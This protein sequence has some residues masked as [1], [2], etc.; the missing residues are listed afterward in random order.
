MTRLFVILSLLATLGLLA[1]PGPVRADQPEYGVVGQVQ[2]GTPGGPVPEGLEVRL[3]VFQNNQVVDTLTTKADAGGNFAFTGL[4]A[5][6]G[7][8]YVPWVWYQG[9]SYFGRQVSFV[10]VDP[11]QRADITIYEATD[12][13]EKVAIQ[14]LSVAVADVNPDANQVVIFSLVTFSNR[15]DRTYVSR[16]MGMDVGFLPLPIPAGAQNIVF[17]GGPQPE[18]LLRTPQGYGVAMSVPPGDL[19]L[20]FAYVIPYDGGRLPVAVTPAFPVER[21]LVLVPRGALGAEGAGLTPH[22]QVDIQNQTFDLYVATGLP[23]NTPAEFNLTGLPEPGLL[24]RLTSSRVLPFAVVGGGGV[25]LA[26]LGLLWARRRAGRRAVGGPRD[27]DLAERRTRLVA[28]LAE[29][30]DRYERGE[31]KSDEYAERRAALK[32]ELLTVTRALAAR[33]GQE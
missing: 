31:V 9:A 18:D 1:G 29:L 2:N 13:A 11:V 26:A 7:Y 20:A 33:Q 15:A 12:S 32:A 8:T 30:D 23:P 3:A 6:P 24:A 17:H 16:P 22:G 28:A 25:I 5:D 10:N 14:M 21:L 4:K 27:E 19:D